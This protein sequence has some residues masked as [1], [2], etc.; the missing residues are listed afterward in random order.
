MERISLHLEEF[1]EKLNEELSSHPECLPGMTI[2]ILRPQL[3]YSYD[4]TVVFCH[5]RYQ[6]DTLRP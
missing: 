1:V 6:Y 3:K 5:F 4:S 2:T